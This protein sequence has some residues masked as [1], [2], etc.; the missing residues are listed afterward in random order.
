MSDSSIARERGGAGGSSLLHWPVKYAKSHVF[1]VFE[2]NFCWK[3]ENS[4]P[5][6]IWEPKLQS[7]CRDLTWKTFWISDFGRKIRF[8]SGEDFFLFLF[9]RSPCFWAKKPFEYP[10]R[11]KIFGSKQWK[12]ASRSLAVVSLFQ[13]SPL[14]FSNPG[15]ACGVRSAKT[16]FCILVDRAMGGAGAIAPLATMTITIIYVLKADVTYIALTQQLLSVGNFLH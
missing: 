3:N 5:K 8:N 2:A 4:P 1:C 13:N 12:F 9:W 15:Y 7:R 14:P 11:A 6:G 16:L 10:T